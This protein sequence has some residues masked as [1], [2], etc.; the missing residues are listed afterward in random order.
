MSRKKAGAHPSAPVMKPEA[1][2]AGPAVTA[3]VA[4]PAT[5]PTAVSTAHELQRRVPGRP[6][7]SGAEWTGNAA[8][9]AP[10]SR[11]KLTE[12]FLATLYADW[13]RNG[14]AAIVAMREAD[15]AAYV[16]VVASLVP[17]EASLDVNVTPTLPRP[18]AEMTDA[19]WEIALGIRVTK[20]SEQ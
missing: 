7:K 8:G 16:K 11:N 17:R 9:R 20:R 14:A 4:R 18:L 2:I 15:P 6:F 1:S 3:A 19:D 10:G 12:D 13:Q 5:P